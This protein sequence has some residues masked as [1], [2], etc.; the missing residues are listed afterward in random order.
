MKTF[1]SRVLAVV[2]VGLV[3]L[4]GCASGPRIRAQTANGAEIQRYRTYGYLEKLGT[5]TATYA[6]AMSLNLKAATDREMQARGFTPAATDPDLVVNFFLDQKEKIQ[7]QSGPSFGLGVG[8]GWGAWRTG[9]AWGF[10]M[11]D[12]W[13]DSRTEG[14]LTIDVVDRSKNEIVW[15]GTAVGTVTSKMLDDPRAAVDAV[16]PKIFAKFPARGAP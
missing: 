13:I 1:Q 11:S 8:R 12:T 2:V 4:S 7:G 9:Y 14:T 15:S 16:V 6:S 10:G 3:A 5:D